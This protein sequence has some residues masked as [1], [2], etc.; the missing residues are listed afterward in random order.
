MISF[1]MGLLCGAAS[2]YRDWAF[3]CP[4]HILPIP[5][6]YGVGTPRLNHTTPAQGS[7]Q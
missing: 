5:L 2:R 1:R 3:P 6:A 4:C 7:S